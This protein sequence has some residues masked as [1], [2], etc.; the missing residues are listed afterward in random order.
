M[1]EVMAEVLANLFGVS[2][3]VVRALARRGVVVKAAR[4]S[5]ALVESVRAYC[6][7]LREAAAGRGTGTEPTEQSTQRARPW[8]AAS[9]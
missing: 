8:L 3:E 5:F 2:G 1:Q 6:T 7:H 9:A 4:N